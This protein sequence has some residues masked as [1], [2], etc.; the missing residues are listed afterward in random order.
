MVLAAN[1][2]PV[3]RDRA[4]QRWETSPG[5]LVS[6]LSS[7]VA[8]Q[9]V[10]WVGWPGERSRRLEPFVH[11]GTL[12]VPVSIEEGELAHFYDGFSN[13]TLW[14]LFHDLPVRPR[15][16]RHWW[17]SY[18][19]VNER[20]AGAVAAVAAEGALVWVHDY[21]L[22]L[23]PRRLR[24]LRPDLRIG[25]FLHVPFPSPDLYVQLPWRSELMEGV[26]GADVIGVQTSPDAVNL[27]AA[28][29]LTG[30]LEGNGG[31]WRDG[32]RPVEIDSFPISV[33]T[34]AI[35]AAA[36]TE[37]TASRAAALRADLGAPRAVLLGVDR[38][39]YTKGITVRLR[40]L[41]ELLDD[42]VLS[43]PD[44]VVFV[45]VA[46]PSRERLGTYAQERRQISSLVGEINGR[47][48]RI[49]QPVV[50]YISRN[51]PFD[52]LVVLYRAADVMLVTPLKDGMNLVAKEY[53]AARVDGRGALVLSEFAGAARELDEA[54][55]VNPY[56]VEAVKRAVVGAVR[57]PAEE[58]AE[59]LGAMR[60]RL[61]SADVHRWAGG[62]VERLRR[63]GPSPIVAA[64]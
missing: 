36:S 17:S 38:L 60:H 28:A 33:D 21:H 16:H 42:G 8:E 12:L 32:S 64:S 24:T 29:R 1:R 10:A 44:E 25:F 56:D 48:G 54:L 26:S 61:E 22:M 30:A 35:E 5:G 63:S 13:A 50:H 27:A 62:F 53:V 58:Q 9:D 59:R 2:L 11:R 34:A 31:G 7:V 6:A 45:Q 40:A 43:G 52:E 23:V 20:F 41:L 46:V 57:M 14:P 3:R 4:K 51:L 55:I 47:H 39:D 15:Y 19:A 37:S 49:G 18:R